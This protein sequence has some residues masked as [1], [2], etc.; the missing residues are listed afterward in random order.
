MLTVPDKSPVS[1]QKRTEEQRMEEERMRDVVRL[2]EVITVREEATIKMILDCLYDVGSVNL[3]N[4]RVRIRALNR[5]V[6]WIARFTK[7][8]FRIIAFR[9]FKKN[10]PQLITNWLRS[11]VTF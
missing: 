6:K 2:L 1:L 8:A 10:C 7:P 11:K 9:W 5:L 4:Q 3:I